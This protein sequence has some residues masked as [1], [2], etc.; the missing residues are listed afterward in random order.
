M[1][2]KLIERKRDVT[3]G[4]DETAIIWL[5]KFNADIL[6]KQLKQQQNISLEE[7]RKASA[8]N[9]RTIRRFSRMETLNIPPVE[10][11]QLKISYGGVPA[12]E[13]FDIHANLSPDRI[14]VTRDGSLIHSQDIR[15]RQLGTYMADTASAELTTFNGWMFR[16]H[17]E[18]F[19][20]LGMEQLYGQKDS[21]RAIYDRIT[22]D[23]K[24]SGCQV[25]LPQFDH[26]E[27]RSRIRRAFTPSR[28]LKI[29]EEII[30]EKASLLR[31][32]AGDAAL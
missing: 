23:A 10:F 7:F 26:D 14:I 5:N 9:L 28:R 12:E 15:G 17:K 1:Y 4:N 29:N 18:S 8:D 11:Y 24:V 3:R 30:P 22:S 2:Y 16:L 13:D 19:G 32:Q 6:N 20:L 25:P 21:L 27:I 31:H